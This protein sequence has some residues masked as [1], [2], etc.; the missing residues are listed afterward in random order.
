L[1]HMARFD[2]EMDVIVRLKVIWV[3]W[4]DDDAF[5]FILAFVTA[6]RD[7]R[8]HSMDKQS[9]PRYG[10]NNVFDKLVE[11]SLILCDLLL[12][13]VKISVLLLV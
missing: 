4:I 6:C 3:F 2:R 1:D 11:R 5:P 9:I 13:L 7:G 8:L 12:R 10:V